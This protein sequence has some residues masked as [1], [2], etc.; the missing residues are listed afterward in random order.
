M[1]GRQVLKMS[2]EITSG[3]ISKAQKVVIY[4][5]EGIGKSTF[6][7]HFPDPLFIDTENGSGNLDVRRYP[8][9]SSWTMLK[10]EV[11]EVAKTRNCKTLVIDTVDWA[12]MLCKDYVCSSKGKSGIEDFGY[13]AGY[14]FMYE[15]FGK[16]LNIL[17]DVIKAGINVV[18]TAHAQLRKFSQPDEIGEYD[19]WELKLSKK[20]GAQISSL[21]KEWADMLL[22]ANYKTVAVAVN[23]DGTKFKAQGNQRVMYTTHHACWDAKNRYGL[24]DE[25]PFSYDAIAHIFAQSAAGIQAESSTE[26]P[27]NNAQIPQTPVPTYWFDGENPYMTNDGNPPQSSK[28]VF[29]ITKEEYDRLC[30]AKQAVNA[31][32]YP[33]EIQPETQAQSVPPA[34]TVTA[35]IPESLPQALRDLMRNSG[36]SV[37]EIQRVVGMKGYYPS[38]TPVENYDPGFVNGVLV[39]A[40]EQVFDM[41]K[42]NRELDSIPFEMNV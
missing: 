33:P 42:Q 37:G 10:E 16:F 7:A 8:C 9:P 1:D 25:L 35:D 39:G 6:A 18:C 32:E 3:R 38:D 40:W 27:A 14:V 19:R 12:E 4:G 31:N 11:Y 5:P 22:F 20:T 41:I 28:P 15:E 2:F 36:V 29:S 24:P 21:I 34:T 17:E 26:I 30:A 13:G 23:K